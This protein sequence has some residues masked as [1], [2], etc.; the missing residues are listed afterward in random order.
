MTAAHR[1]QAARY[2]EWIANQR[3]LR[4]TIAEMAAISGQAA[5]LILR[6]NPQTP[7]NPGTSPRPARESPPPTQPNPQVSEFCR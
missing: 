6:K 1:P 4:A 7:E 3:E 5:E 2:A